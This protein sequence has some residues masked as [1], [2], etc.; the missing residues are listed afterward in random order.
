MELI[1]VARLF[2]SMQ[3]IRSSPYYQPNA[4]RACVFVAAVDTLNQNG[5]HLD[6]MSALFN[7]L[8]G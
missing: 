2:H 1:E 7:S 5:M 4:S 6:L 3:V 8:P